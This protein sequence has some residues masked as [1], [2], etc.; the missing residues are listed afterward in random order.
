MPA[1]RRPAPPP[2]T[3]EQAER[4]LADY[5]RVGIKSLA[6][7]YGLGRR[8]LRD[9]LVAAGAA[10]R[11]RDVPAEAVP[12]AL[13]MMRAGASYPEIR[14]AT[15]L[16]DTTVRR[17]ARR[18]GVVY[19]PAECPHAANARRRWADPAQRG[20]QAEVARRIGLAGAV[21]TPDARRARWEACNPHL[22]D[23]TRAELAE[24]KFLR[25][26]GFARDEALALLGP[27]D[28]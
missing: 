14:R 21:Q 15:G 11:G 3:P 13:A 23:F 20:A 17:H 2:W 22:A 1:P 7:L 4:A 12:V 25:A 24:Y 9:R 26:K 28:A 10:V 16:S 18:A 5:T 27:G 8:D 19:A 6:A